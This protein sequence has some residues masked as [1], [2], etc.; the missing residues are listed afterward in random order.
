VKRAVVRKPARKAARKIVRKPAKKAARKAAK[1]PA[2]KVA[3]KVV[4]K[5]AKKPA[6]KPAE[7]EVLAIVFV[8][9]LIALLARAEQLKGAPLTRV[10]VE[11]IRDEGACI[12]LPAS[13]VADVDEGRGYPDIDPERA[14]EQWQAVRVSVLSAMPDR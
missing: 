12:A 8:P 6:R 7:D 3:R 5:A 14:W 10:E 2:K 4:R 1:K 9:A 13:A 11:R